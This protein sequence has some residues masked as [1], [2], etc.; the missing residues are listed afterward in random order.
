MITRLGIQVSGLKE[1]ARD[2]KS[3]AGLKKGLKAALLEG[4]NVVA[5][6]WERRL[7]PFSRKIA[8]TVKPGAAGSSA[9][10]K[11]G[12]AKAPH[13]V[14]FEND[15]KD[16]TFRHPVFGNRKLWVSQKA[17]P[18]ATQALEAAADEALEATADAIDKWARD[19]GF[20]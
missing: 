18:T 17:H 16:G 11:A 4:A 19:A 3:D 1:L 8:S 6:E 10:V 2:I 20:S 7:S 15:G 9:Y 14:P 12:G 13:A 5:I